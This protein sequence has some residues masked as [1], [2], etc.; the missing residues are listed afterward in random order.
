MYP[1]IS[2]TLSPSFP[3]CVSPVSPHPHSS[4]VSETVS[5]CV[6]I[7]PIKQLDGID[8]ISSLPSPVPSLDQG[9]SSSANKPMPLHTRVRNTGY[10]LDRDKQIK[11]LH[12]DTEGADFSI[13]VNNKNENV[14]IRCNTGFY[15]TVAVP[16]IQNLARSDVL[17]FGG[18]AVR[19]QHIIGNLD[20]TQ[21]LQTSVLRFGLWK[22]DSSLGSV[23]IHLHHTARK[24]QLQGG[25]IMPNR[26]TS[27][28]WFVD[29][30]L[31]G[32]FERLSREKAGDIRSLNQA[33][34][35]SIETT[36]GELPGKCNGCNL[37]FTGRSA[38]ELCPQC[39]CYYHKKCFPSSKHLCQDKARNRSFSSIYGA[40]E[41]QSMPTSAASLIEPAPPLT[42]ASPAQLATQTVW[43]P[44]A[45][46]PPATYPAQS[47]G[48]PATRHIM[49][50]APPLST[51]LT[52]QHHVNPQRDQAAGGQGPPQT[53]QAVPGPAAS[54]TEQSGISS[55]ITG[56]RQTLPPRSQGDSVSNSLV[57]IIP[58]QN[59][60]QNQRK[61]NARKKK[62]QIPTDPAGI[63][64]EFVNAEISTLQAKLQKQQTELED[65]KFRNSILMDRNKV[66][67]EEKTKSIHD[68]YFPS[69]HQPSQ[70]QG[71]P[72][73]LPT[74][75]S[76]CSHHHS[77]VPP[78]CPTLSTCQTQRSCGQASE[79]ALS[80]LV[81]SLQELMEIV[82]TMQLHI[83]QLLQSGIGVR[84]SP[85]YSMPPGPPDIH[86]PSD[87][88]LLPDP[89]LQPGPQL[90]PGL[91]PQP[92]YHSSPETMIQPTQPESVVQSPSPS[93]VSLDG[94]MFDE[95]NL[96]HN[97][98]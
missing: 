83:N 10:M 21:A 16:T 30:V 2:P 86:H 40:S 25:A 76:C 41:Q 81:S 93:I 97:L 96:N 52:Q 9:Q 62:S 27:P 24:I 20:N 87:P 19:C 29:S 3:N 49:Q 67:E 78:H 45:P 72:S 98:N 74:T 46:A 32:H 12:K 6:D 44:H 33:I 4:K 17:V 38:P 89:H 58:A 94:F 1:S 70:P 59:D 7:S 77:C 18:V 91:H 14:T 53:T 84:S 63:A 92:D 50:P 68:R 37:K 8:D 75:Q 57:P 48:L 43:T 39:S 51:T 55:Y 42:Q 11:R 56:A 26:S 95:E 47:A 60:E 71:P 35:N 73:Y 88:H 15:S 31:R 80:E 64:L 90:Q 65:L 23:R 69:S 13:E 5:I 85:Q 36:S 28:V 22:D 34:S 66:L 79:T 61:S 54:Q 82:K